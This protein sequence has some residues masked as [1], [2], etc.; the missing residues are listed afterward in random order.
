LLLEKNEIQK[1]KMQIITSSQLSLENVR[2]DVP[3]EQ[4]ADR[5]MR[6]G[7]RHSALALLF[8]SEENQRKIWNA[9]E[10][11]VSQLSEMPVQIYVDQ[12]SFQDMEET[13]DTAMNQLPESGILDRMNIKTI[14]QQTEKY[15]S[16]IRRTRLYH[17]W[18]IKGDRPR[19]ME[20]PLLTN[21]RQRIT[22]PSG[23][24]YNLLHPDSNRWLDFQRS[25]QQVQ[26]GGF[27]IP[28]LFSRFY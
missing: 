8:F 10:Q 5:Y 1:I 25:Q 2:S 24:S 7:N 18:F 14:Q 19:T 11:N 4:M 20:P 6:Q 13:A 21:G 23:E 9:V 15:F 17:K 22:R 12:E 28:A 27:T 3:I 16:R 26:S